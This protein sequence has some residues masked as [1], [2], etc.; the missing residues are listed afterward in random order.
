MN[1]VINQFE[2]DVQL[3]D[4]LQNFVY[5]Y[6]AEALLHTQ[7]VTEAEN[8][9]RKIPSSSRFY[10]DAKYGMGVINFNKANYS[11]VA[12]QN[13]LVL[14]EEYLSTP[15]GIIKEKAVDA[16]TRIATIYAVN[17]HYKEAEVNFMKALNL[18][19]SE[20]EYINFSLGQIYFVDNKYDKAMRKFDEV[21]Q[22]PNSLYAQY[23]Q[24]M[25]AKIYENQSNRRQVI[26]LLDDFIKRYPQ[27]EKLAEALYI[28]G[29]AW[30]GLGENK[31]A[32]NDYTALITNYPSTEKAKM[33]L[34]TLE[35]YPDFGIE[36][37]NI[38]EL[39]DIYAKNN[40][41]YNPNSNIYNPNSAVSNSTT[42]PIQKEFDEGL[43]LYQNKDFSNAIATFRNI[44]S[45]NE[46][47][48]T[49]YYDLVYYHLGK[50]YQFYGDNNQAIN[51][52]Q[53][54]GGKLQTGALA[55][56]GDIEFGREN[57][58]SA[59]THY[60]SLA[61]LAPNDAMRVMAWEQLTKTYC[62]QEDYATANDYLAIIRNKK[63]YSNTDFVR[64]YENKI[65]AG[66]QQDDAAIEGFSKLG[67]DR[68]ANPK[69]A[70]EALLE[71][72]KLM[73]KIG[74]N[75]SAKS[76]LKDLKKQ[77]TEQTEVQQ[78]AKKLALLLD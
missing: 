63:S 14:L 65:L 48:A 59:I 69:Y 28:R 5:F 74:D 71:L 10:A 35:N 64:L 73:H 76:I 52:L 26:A 15:K 60:K 37:E 78:K 66:Q 12:K 2:S 1:R 61:K 19:D 29:N 20:T 54:V 23:S 17:K 50:S 67:N 72:A 13:A 57:Y 77:F 27:S 75:Q 36:V 24:I 6:K 33:A 51:N 34:S 53:R 32:I 31:K 46:I 8:Y 40:S 18:G 68:Q 38:Q 39:R 56:M 55:D 9:Y 41:N 16:L 3:N 25:K 44:I 45:K 7:K 11:S 47:A 58:N 4:S 42:N 22:T 62:M 30:N 43:K 21:M 70:S 49:P